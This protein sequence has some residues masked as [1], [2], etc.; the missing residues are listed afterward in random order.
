MNY[1]EAH[2]QKLM[3]SDSFKKAYIEESIKFFD[4]EITLQNLIDDIKN[5]RSESTILKKLKGLEQFVKKD[6]HLSY[7]L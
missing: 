1:A 7:N 2:F 6:F 3:E 5:H 4:I